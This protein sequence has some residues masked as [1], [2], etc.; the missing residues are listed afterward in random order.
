MSEKE[1]IKTALNTTPELI[2]FFA[3]AQAFWRVL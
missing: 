2:F 3:T 1:K